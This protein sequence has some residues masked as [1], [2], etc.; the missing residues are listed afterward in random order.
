MAAF[1]RFALLCAAAAPAASLLARSAS[2]EAH[3]TYVFFAGLEGSGHHFLKLV[4]EACM[5]AG[6][7]GKRSKNFYYRAYHSSLQ[8]NA[9][10]MSRL[11]PLEDPFKGDALFTPEE[12]KVYPMNPFVKGNMMSYPTGREQQLPQL[13]E[14]DR[15]AKQFGDSFKVVVMLRNAQDLFNSDESRWG[16]KES[17]L[18]D[19]LETM[20]AQL[21]G[22]SPDQYMCVKFENFGEAGSSLQQFLKIENFDLTGTMQALYQAE[23]RCG[24][25]EK[26]CPEAPTLSEADRKFRNEFCGNT[27]SVNFGRSFQRLHAHQPSK[28]LSY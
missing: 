2:G 6:S 4:V 11:W 12:G 26:Q 17:T 19:A 22:L 25:K 15:V 3:G 13:L 23:P 7:C 8:P 10:D 5:E 20:S 16:R 14:F 9:T 1:T 21:R 18:V 27:A 24:S 28:W